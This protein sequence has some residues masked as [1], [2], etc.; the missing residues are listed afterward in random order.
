MT[1]VITDGE[2]VTFALG[3]LAAGN[4]TTTNLIINSFYCFLVDSPGIYEELRKEPNLILKAIEE[5]L[6]YRFPVTLTRRITALS[7]RESPSPLGM[8]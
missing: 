6:R 4:E 2:I 5:V 3:L 8:G 7:E 1:S